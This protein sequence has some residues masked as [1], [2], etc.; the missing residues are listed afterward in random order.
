MTLEI[1]IIL[2]LLV[3]VLIA[4][5]IDRIPTDA[6]ALG[7]IVL[8]I[9]TGLLTPEEAI[10]GFSNPATIT[11]L[12]LFFVSQS[13]R[14][15]GVVRK[16]G[17]VLLSASSDKLFINIILIMVVTAVT[18][19]FINTTAVVIV[20]LP[21][22]L[23]LAKA[24]AISPTVL[25]MPLSFGAII[26]G[27]STTIGTST[28]LLIHDI[29]IKSGGQPMNI[30]EFSHIGLILFVVICGYM[31]LA[32]TFYLKSR[33]KEKNL[34][35]DYNLK[36]YFAE[37]AIDETSSWVGKTIEQIKDI[38]LWEIDVLEIVRDDESMVQFIKKEIL[39]AGDSLLIRINANNLMQLKGRKGIHVGS[40][41]TM[42]DR[43]LEDKGITLLEVV[44]NTNSP[45]IGKRIPEIMFQD[46][47]DANILGVIGSHNRLHSKRMK[48][49]KLRFGDTL[50]IQTPDENKH[51]FYENEAFFVLQEHQAPTFQT[52]KQ[53]LAI[54]T[55][56][57]MVGLAAFGI[58]PILVT[59]LAAATILFLTGVVPINQAY[60]SV[61]W[62]I[63]FLLAGLIPM[64]LALQQT[65]AS[66]LLAEQLSLLVSN[67]S[68][69][70]ALFVL[71]IITTLL[72]SIVYNNA[73]A[74]IITPILLSMAPA[75]GVDNNAMLAMAI[76]ASNCC[77]LTP[78]G[79]QTNLL[80]Y[81]PGQYRFS[82]FLIV[83]GPLC[84][85]LGLVCSYLVLLF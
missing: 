69:Y 56:V 11:I 23:R 27:S 65:G 22:V 71:Y 45:L 57:A 9:L 80:I 31:I 68:T 73:T 60:Q 66:D 44:I 47:Y 77:F 55:I 70:W 51:T 28:N 79:Y 85:L 50:L 52:D 16:L 76:F 72:T 34:I 81:G 19:A 26:G 33:K 41:R 78:I 15:T 7:T 46:T 6:I 25:L 3:L 12:A 40:K 20:F 63:I 43:D 59:A 35:S 10:S 13:L 54:L 53:W 74:V 83:G 84:I 1:V 61:E 64:G 37:V 58:L 48:E 62:R 49:V 38:R 8:L 5:I 36:N 39:Q 24:R 18:S 82:D 14:N 21:V 75:L 4:F 32:S 30:F 2:S 17:D 67:L 42:A 29:N